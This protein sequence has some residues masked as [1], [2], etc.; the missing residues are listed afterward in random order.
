MI[1]RRQAE[2]K[3]L[4]I[5]SPYVDVPAGG[6]VILSVVADRRGYDGPIQLTIPD[7]PK[8]VTVEGGIIPRE[9]IDPNNTR[10]FNRRGILTITAD[11]GVDLAGVDLADRPL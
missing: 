8:G 2:E 1:N 4:A 11:P 6:T 7:L 3:Q 5:G 9:Y 10:T